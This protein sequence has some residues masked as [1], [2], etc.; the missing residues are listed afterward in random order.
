MRDPLAI[1]RFVDKLQH[2]PLGRLLAWLLCTRAGDSVAQCS[3]LVFIVLPRV[4]ALV[5]HKEMRDVM[6]TPSVTYA[7]YGL[8]L[9]TLLYW[10]Y[11]MSYDIATRC[12]RLFTCL[13]AFDYAMIATTVTTSTFPKQLHT[14][15]HACAVT[16]AVVLDQY[17]H[18]VQHGGTLSGYATHHYLC[19]LST[20]IGVYRSWRTRRWTPTFVRSY[21]TCVC[22]MVFYLAIQRDNSKVSNTYPRFPWWLPWVWHVHAALCQQ[23]SLEMAWHVQNCARSE[24]D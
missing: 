10:N 19:A 14:P 4:F 18:Y 7:N 11:V 20:A 16:C 13:Y 21:S 2:Q 3:G 22:T 9:S 15:L 1:R 24:G 6:Y 8:T 5:R 17:R 23:T 12:E